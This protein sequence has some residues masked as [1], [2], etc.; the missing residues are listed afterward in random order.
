MLAGPPPRLGRGGIG[1]LGAAAYAATLW[2]VSVASVLTGQEEPFGGAAPPKAAAAAKGKAGK[3]AA[4]TAPQALPLALRLLE[5]SKPSQPAELVRAAAV[6]LEH[7]RPDIARNYLQR[8]L[9]EAPSDEALAPLAVKLADLLLHFAAS[10]D[11]QPLGQQIAD[12]VFAAAR[13]Q[14]QDP[15]RLAQAIAQLAAPAPA[16]RA[17]AVLTLADAGPSGIAALI[18]VLADPARASEHAAIRSALVTLTSDNP[19]PLVAVL[20]GADEPLALQVLTVLGRIGAAPLAPF[21]IGHAVSPRAPQAVREL[22]TLALVRM[23]LT[24]PNVGQARRLIASQ[25]QELVGGHLPERFPAEERVPLWHRAPDST[26]GWEMQPREQAA[27]ALAQALVRHLA[28]LADDDASR[29]EAWLWQLEVLQ[30]L[31]GLDRPLNSAALASEGLAAESALLRHVLERALR[32]GRW[33]AALA[34]LTWLAEA[35]DGGLLAPD[36]K[37]A[38]A[39]LLADALQSPDR[40]VRLSA[41]LAGVKLAPGSSFPGAGMIGSTLGWAASSRGTSRLLVGHPRAEEAQRLIVA[42]AARGYEAQAVPSGRPLVAQATR[43]P[44]CEG[45]LLADNLSQPPVE[46]VVAWLRRDL[47]TAQLPVVVLATS[48]RQA[49]L[50]AALADDPF[51][52]VVLYPYSAEAAA[53]LPDELVRLA[54]ATLVPRHARLAHAAQ[55]LEALAVLGRQPAAWQA[56]GLL[57]QE[58][59]ILAALTQPSLAVAAAQVLG[60]LGTPAAQKALWE[61]AMDG[62]Q[63]LTLRQAAATALARAT[64]RRGLGLTSGQVAHYRQRLASAP[65]DPATAPLYGE[66]M[67]LLSG[68][69]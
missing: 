52:S 36:P 65:A 35:G 60:E 13:R 8:L 59:A 14:A 53:K 38:G 2:A 23:G 61:L 67:S 50:A 39:S 17:E 9:S 29:Q 10:P 3:E 12:R 7:Q 6:A 62:G 63:P 1:A 64:T 22:A 68:R 31:S 27:L 69:P 37:R 55:A 15:S 44:D 20:D 30:R 18:A 43:D 28:A 19:W 45:V 56:Y 42:V 34:S 41:A 21:V 16:A 33:G 51:T 58:E 54:G 25:V 40:R 47:R 26:L 11:L 32:E 4:E 46:E 49:T 57:A 66:L 48:A 24:Q 5:E